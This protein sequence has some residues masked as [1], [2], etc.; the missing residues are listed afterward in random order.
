LAA[1]KFLTARD[2]KLKIRRQSETYN[3]AFAEWRKSH[4]QT[5]GYYPGDTGSKTFTFTNSVFINAEASS[6]R[7]TELA[8][9]KKTLSFIGRLILFISVFIVFFHVGIPYIIEYAFDG[10]VYDYHEGELYGTDGKLMSIIIAGSC[11]VFCYSVILISGTLLLKIPAAV[12]FPIVPVIKKMFPVGI[13]VALS[14]AAVGTFIRRIIGI[15]E[16]GFIVNPE[17]TG[18]FPLETIIQL[19][20]YVIIIPILSELAF[21]GVLLSLLRQFGDVSAV[22]LSAMLSAVTSCALLSANITGVVDEPFPGVMVLIFPM[23]FLQHL[24]FGYFAFTSGSVGTP[25]CMS[26]VIAAA[27]A[28]HILLLD[29]QS[30]SGIYIVALICFAAGFFAILSLMTDHTDDIEL[31]SAN[32]SLKTSAIF[33]SIVSPEFLLPLF[34]LILTAFIPN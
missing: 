13:A 25:I 6:N 4:R 20:I 32:N 30:V 11:A 19:G 21:R 17:S 27:N 22:V 7:R 28:A 31:I 2:D 1:I 23:A 33:L 5:L 29:L 8:A 14:L 15:S 26:I 10:I 9:F 16:F 18:E 12:V 3:R 24:V 34:L